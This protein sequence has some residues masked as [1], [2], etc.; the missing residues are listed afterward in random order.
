MFP[1]IH[2]VVSQA[3]AAGVAP[4]AAQPGGP[5]M[6]NETSWAS[7]AGLTQQLG[8]RFTVGAANIT[9]HSLRFYHATGS[10]ETVRLWRVS[11]GALLASAS[12]TSTG[13]WG[14]EEIPPV[15]LLTGA[16][17]VVAARAGGSSRTVHHTPTDAA[18]DPA[19]TF[20]SGVFN[21]ADAFPASTTGT[22]Y[23]AASL[24]TAAPASGYRFYRLALA[25][26]NGG[27]TIVGTHELGLRESLGGASV[28]VGAGGLATASRADLAP[29]M[30][31]DGLTT[32]GNGWADTSGSAVNT[33]WLMYDFGS[34]NGVNVVQ[35]TVASYP[36]SSSTAARSPNSWTLQA[37][38][39]LI[40]WEDLDTVT[41]ETGWTLTEE[42][43]FTL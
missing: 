9:V 31:F 23:M 18:I 33:K 32:S 19:I 21:N 12:V 13:G 2:G 30:A 41:G 35:Y 24:R 11:D 4:P 27:G 14:E 39:D 37:S 28:A 40:T 7:A 22:A 36:T 16:Q 29:A 25:S 1:T 6:Y 10:T 20:D 17:Y 15:T 43:V 42:R 3:L 5:I 38:N 34:A 26:N 8:W